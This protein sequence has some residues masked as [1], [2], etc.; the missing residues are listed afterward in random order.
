M[1]KKTN[2][3]KKIEVTDHVLNDDKTYVIPLGGLEEVG[4]NMTA[5]QYKDEIIVVDAGATFPDNE[6]LGIDLIIPNMKY[7]EEN[8]DK[9][10]A[11]LLTHG[12]ED[13]IGAVS[14]FYQILGNQIP[15]YGGRLSLALALSKFERKEVKKPVTKNVASRTPI[16]ISK[17]FEVEFVSVTHSIADCYAIRIKTPTASILH[18]GDFKVDLT[19]VSGEG[20][21]F[22]RLSQMGEEGIDLL[23][24]DSTNAKIKGF[25]PSERT[26]GQGIDNIVAKAKGRVILAAFASHVHRIQQIIYIAKKYNRKIAIDGRS[27]NKIFD[28]CHKLGYLDIPKNIMI[29]L[30]KAEKMAPEKVLIL[31]T[32][33]QGEPMAA[34]SRIANG[35]HKYI[36]LHSGDTVIISASP[37]PGNEVAA[38]KNINQL[39]KKNVEVVFDKND[40]IHVSGHGCQEEQKIMLNLIKPKYFMPV[41]GDY[42]MLKAHKDLAIAVG[43]KDENILL[44]ENGQKIAITYDA[45]KVASKVPSGIVLIDGYGIGDVGQSVIKDRQNLSEDGIVVVSVVMK[46]DGKFLNDVEILTKGFV[47]TKDA[48]ELINNARNLVLLE[49]KDIESKK[50]TEKYKVSNI[51]K[52]KLAV[53]FNKEMHRVPMVLTVVTEI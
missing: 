23:L 40:G 36:S 4:K 17:Y 51:I 1:E 22:A 47:Y 18:T 29:N 14:Y 9:I 25:T 48:T 37:I 50:I 21:D 12:H 46:K 16:K 26:V 34:L 2:R 33:T 30:Q 8:K 28:I 49:L 44:A 35:T 27:M 38:F 52:Q 20:F 11:L 53:F 6:H 10:K 43:I 3:R 42:S 39:M 5:I 41:H 32:G 15:M 19:P 31:C 7:L 24:S 45:I 13:H